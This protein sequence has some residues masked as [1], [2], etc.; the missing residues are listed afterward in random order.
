MDAQRAR[1]AADILW[2]AWQ[3]KRLLEA[4]P[5]PGERL[6]AERELARLN[7]AEGRTADADR[8]YRTSLET[9]EAARAELKNDDSKL[10]FLANATRVYDDYI[11]FLVAH[12]KTGE[13]LVLA[14]RSRARTLEQGLGV[15]SNVRS[16]ANV[17]LH[18][19]EI[20]H[21]NVRAALAWLERSGDASGMTSFSA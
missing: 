16:S 2:S 4:L 10:P 15:I 19:A 9:F 6:G 7:E 1:Q 20:E 3:E 18:P 5:G 12:R 17:R 11:H 14:D 8:M 21:D 13:A